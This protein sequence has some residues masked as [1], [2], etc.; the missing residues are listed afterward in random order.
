MKIDAHYYA[1]LAFSLAAGINKKTAHKIAYA[2]QFVDDAKINYLIVANDKNFKLT[3]DEVQGKK[4]FYDMA[5]CHSYEK[6]KTFNFN[7]MI[8]NTAAFHFPPGCEGETFERKL[9]C[10][11]DNKAINEILTKAVNDSDPIKLGLVLHAYADTFS[12]QG[13]S[14]LLSAVN[15]IDIISEG[16]VYKVYHSFLG[17]IWRLFSTK[18]KSYFANKLS[19][20]VLPA[21]GHG[22]AFI[23]PDVPFLEWKFDYDFCDRF[24]GEKQTMIAKNKERFTRAFKKIETHLASFAKNNPDLCEKDFKAIDKT[25]LFEALLF[26]GNDKK[27]IKNWKR[28]MLKLGLLEENSSELFY[29]ENLWLKEAFSNF[30]KKKFDKRTVADVH[31]HKDFENSSWYNFY[32]AVHWYKDEFYSICKAHGLEIPA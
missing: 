13:F 17:N 25:H 7:S 30:N 5:S 6:M 20:Y 1:V 3:F 10:K 8:G 22:Q 21:Y 18:I 12:H 28:T 31:L 19:D 27:R 15:D 26:R 24:S 23:Y 2:S 32:R 9:V 4:C 11:E 16:D 29:E 14:G